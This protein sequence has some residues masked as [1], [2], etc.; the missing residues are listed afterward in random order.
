MDVT[1]KLHPGQGFTPETFKRLD[2]AD[3]GM[4]LTGF[5][6]MIGKGAPV[7]GTLR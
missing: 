4:M 1:S 6:A 5:K 3:I 2:G 7:H